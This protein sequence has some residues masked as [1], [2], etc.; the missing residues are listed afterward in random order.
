MKIPKNLPQFEKNSGAIIVAGNLNADFYLAKDGEINKVSGFVVEKSKFSDREQAGKYGSVF[1]QSG[2]KAAAMKNFLQKESF[3][4]FKS[5]L[6]NVSS[7]KVVYLFAPG[8]IMSEL[9]KLLPKKWEKTLKTYNGNFA[10]LSLVN[11][12]K[13]I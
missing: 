8:T 3:I 9:Q 10:K 4:A 12:L 6:K 5:N 13:K 1:F 2:D 11:L 7:A